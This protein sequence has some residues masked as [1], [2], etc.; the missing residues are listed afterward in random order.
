MH[1]DAVL[2]G[3]FQRVKLLRRAVVL[4]GEDIHLVEFVGAFKNFLRCVE[5]N[6]SECAVVQLPRS[7]AR[8][9]A[10]DLQARAP[11][12]CADGDALPQLQII[13]FGELSHQHD[14]KFVEV[15]GEERS[16]FEFVV[17]HQ[18]VFCRVDAVYQQSARHNAEET[19][20]EFI[21]LGIVGEQ[22]LRLDKRH[23]GRH[24]RN[25]FDTIQNPLVEST[26]G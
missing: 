26:Q 8:D 20:I 6:N 4:C 14:V 7:F 22:G 23:G 17:A 15:F 12:R 9:Q 11:R 13:L 3:G 10:D 5:W 21:A 24:A 2:Q 18:R 25:R 16:R 1:A 19:D